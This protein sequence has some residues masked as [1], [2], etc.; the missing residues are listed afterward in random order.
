MP[1]LSLIGVLYFFFG[2]NSE[3]W[4]LDRQKMMALVLLIVGL[5][6]IC[7]YAYF[8]FFLFDDMVMFPQ[9]Q[10]DPEIFKSVESVFGSIMKVMI[11]VGMVFLVAVFMAPYIIIKKQLRLL[12]QSAQA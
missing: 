9:T 12:G 10:E 1:F 4:E 6:W 7:F 3:K 11:G 2:K 8:A 5:V